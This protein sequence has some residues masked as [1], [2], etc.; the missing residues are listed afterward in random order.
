MEYKGPKRPIQQLLLQEMSGRSAEAA[1]RRGSETS[2]S[3]KE[4]TPAAK[5][6]YNR[7]RE[8]NPDEEAVEEVEA[9]VQ[10]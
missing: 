2:A 4:K 3:W 1:R 8:L 5:R 6:K 9:F 10:K 7:K